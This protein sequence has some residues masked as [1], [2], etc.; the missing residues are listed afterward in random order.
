MISSTFPTGYDM[1]LCKD[2]SNRDPATAIWYSGASSQK[3]FNDSIASGISC[4]SSRTM[5][6]S[7]GV[8]STPDNALRARSILSVSKSRENTS[9]K[10]WFLRQTKY[11]TFLKYC[12][13][14]CSNSQVLPTCLAPLRIRGFLVVLFFH[15]I[16]FLKYNSFHINDYIF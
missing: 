16:S 11:A 4:T 14:N 1:S 2:I 3:Y 9:F 5:R 7:P 13:P 8:M 6:V 15:S 12:F 10:V